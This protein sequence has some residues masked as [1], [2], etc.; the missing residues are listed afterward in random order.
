M[1]SDTGWWICFWLAMIWA[2]G[3]MDVPSKKTVINIQDCVSS[4]KGTPS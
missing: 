3:L 1:K 2:S 4:Q